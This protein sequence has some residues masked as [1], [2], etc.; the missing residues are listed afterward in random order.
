MSSFNKVF[1][2]GGAIVLLLPVLNYTASK[3]LDTLNNLRDKVNRPIS[4]DIITQ[5]HKVAQA[6]ACWFDDHYEELQECLTKQQQDNF[7]H[8]YRSA[9]NAHTKIGYG[10]YMNTQVWEELFILLGQI[11][12]SFDNE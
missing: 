5:Q 7:E 9:R 11:K 10:Y 6:L 4:P 3:Y 1:H 8:I 2:I 12:H